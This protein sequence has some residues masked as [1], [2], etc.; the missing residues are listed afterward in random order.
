MGQRCDPISA[1]CGCRFD[2][3][4]D[5]RHEF[6]VILCRESMPSRFN[7]LVKHYLASAPLNIGYIPG[8]RMDL[9]TIVKSAI[10]V[11]HQ[12]THH[13]L[14]PCWSWWKLAHAC[15][16]KMMVFLTGN[17]SLV[18]TKMECRNRDHTRGIAN[19]RYIRGRHRQALGIQAS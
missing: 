15:T 4:N 6:Y 17:Q 5:R 12:L 14:P 13:A 10:R 11:P 3:E 8:I 7:A 2:R 1:L 18:W 19:K 9:W 16:H